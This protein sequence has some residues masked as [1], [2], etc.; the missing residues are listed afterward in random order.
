MK[1]TVITVTNYMGRPANPHDQYLYG[2]GA[3]SQA[4]A[5]FEKE[6]QHHPCPSIANTEPGKTILAELINQWMFSSDEDIERWVSAPVK[7]VELMKLRGF[8]TRRIWVPIEQKEGEGKFGNEK[9]ISDFN[10]GTYQNELTRDI[11]TNTV[12]IHL[13]KQIELL[14]SIVDCSR[15]EIIAK[16]CELELQR[17][18]LL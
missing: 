3:L 12:K 9:L 18:E 11:A 10:Y 15:Q 5:Q 16:I 6:V 4:W 7:T 17:S 14:Q 8:R 13:R 2:S 1:P